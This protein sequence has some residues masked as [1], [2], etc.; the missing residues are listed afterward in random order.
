MEYVMF[1]HKQGEGLIAGP[2]DNVVFE[3]E[4]ILV[5]DVTINPGDKT[6]LLS[7]FNRKLIYKGKL[8]KKAVFYMGDQNCMHYYQTLLVVSPTRIYM[9]YSWIGGR[10][11]NLVEGRWK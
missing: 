7:L 5:G 6:D 9:N 1:S 4:S 8:D 10:D 2:N 11:Y 3:K